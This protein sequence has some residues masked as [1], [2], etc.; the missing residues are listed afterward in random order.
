MV[1]ADHKWFAR[2]VVARAMVEALESLDLELSQGRRHR[3]QG[4]AEGAGGA[5]G[6][7]QKARLIGNKRLEALVNGGSERQLAQARG[8]SAKRAAVLLAVNAEFTL[9]RDA[10]GTTDEGESDNA[11]APTYP[12]DRPGGPTGPARRCPHSRRAPAPYRPLRA[13]RAFAPGHSGVD[14]ATEPTSAQ[15]REAQRECKD[16]IP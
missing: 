9:F 16:P 7:G 13:G 11:D 3:A 10:C 1:P 14:R 15:T 4:D 5:A 12:R 2:L 6:R 8:A